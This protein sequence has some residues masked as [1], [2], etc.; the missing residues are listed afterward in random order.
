MLVLLSERGR[1]GELSLIIAEVERLIDEDAGVRRGSLLSAIALDNADV[2]NLTL[3]IAK[4]LKV[5]VKLDAVVDTGLLG[6]FVATVSGKTFDASLKTQLN[7]IRDS[8][9]G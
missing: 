9:L 2:E 3:A 5:K 7:K 1:L 8:I 4:K 6:G